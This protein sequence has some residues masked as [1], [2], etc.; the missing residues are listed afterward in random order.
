[1]KQ[2]PKA[3]VRCSP[4]IGSW[5]V[6]SN[7]GLAPVGDDR[8]SGSAFPHARPASQ[9]SRACSQESASRTSSIC[10]PARR[11]AEALSTLLVRKSNQQGQRDSEIAPLL[12]RFVN[13]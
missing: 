2:V 9:P 8:A 4:S 1:M 5:A 6:Q 7:R 3:E 12:V 11:A 13:Q 10:E